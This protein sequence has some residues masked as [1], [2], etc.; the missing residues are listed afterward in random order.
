[1]RV[2]RDGRSQYVGEVSESGEE[3]ARCAA[4]SRF[5][6]GE[7]EIEAGE[8]APRQVAIYPDEDFDVSPTTSGSGINIY[9]AL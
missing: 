9:S 2:I 7:D 5:G 1:V 3:M 6:V 8:A 4:P